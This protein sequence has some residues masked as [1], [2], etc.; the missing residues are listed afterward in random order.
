M[1]INHKQ[2]LLLLIDIILINI[3]LWF[4]VFLRYEGRIPIS[5]LQN[6]AYFTLVMTAI[7]IVCFSA[8]G[9]YQSLWSYSSLPELFQIFKAVFISSLL[10]YLMVMI[11][12]NFSFSR[13]VFIIDFGVALILTG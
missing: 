7:R 2:P 3:A 4:A 11:L 13:S 5:F 1:K 8:F 10:Q 6:W 12:M 9:L